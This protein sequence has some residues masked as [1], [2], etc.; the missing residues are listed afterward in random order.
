M[1]AALVL[2]SVPAINFNGLMAGPAGHD[3]IQEMYH[4]AMEL[5]SPLFPEHDVHVLNGS[6][7]SSTGGKVSV[8]VLNGTLADYVLDIGP[9]WHPKRFRPDMVVFNFTAQLVRGKEA[10]LAVQGQFNV[11]NQ[12]TGLFPMEIIFVSVEAELM[13]AFPNS[14]IIIHEDPEGLDEKH[15]AMAY[16][17][18][19]PTVNE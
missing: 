17:R 14:E 2:A 16:K 4:V 13:R 19:S 6:I 5:P 7:K 18:V 1:Y 12:S 9:I 3:F 10:P 8:H 15:L 11:F